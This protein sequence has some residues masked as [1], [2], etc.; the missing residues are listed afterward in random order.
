LNEKEIIAA[1]RAGDTDAFAQLVRTN[2]AKVRLVCL[3]LLRNVS[4]ADDAAQD[5]FVKSYESLASFKGEASFGTWVSHIASNHCRDLLRARQRHKTDSLDAIIDQSGEQIQRLLDDPSSERAYTPEDLE[6]LGRLLGGLSEEDREILL[7]R[8]T[9]EMSY[10]EIASR[11]Q[12]SLDAVKG[13]LKRAR[14]TLID[15]FRS[16]VDTSGAAKRP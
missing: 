8:E 2:Q 9:E 4:E 7:L 16:L 15:K 1:V 13:R 5:A 12:C 10:E 11:L 6:L 3:S 14:Q